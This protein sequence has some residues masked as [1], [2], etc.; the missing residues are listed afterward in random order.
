MSKLRFGQGDGL[1]A[2]VDQREVDAG[3]GHQLARMLELALRQVE[4]HRPRAAPGE[5][6]RP[7][8]G[9]AAELEHI[10]SVDV[11]ERVDLVLGD[12][13]HAPARALDAADAGRAVL[14]LLRQ[15]V[16]VGTGVVDA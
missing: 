2:G 10:P 5:R 14:V 9:A 4:A 8:R 7:L 15:R 13:P 16:P 3:L 1:G 12:L 11:A 6:D